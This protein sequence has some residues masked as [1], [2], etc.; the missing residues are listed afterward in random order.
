MI[1]IQMW[2]KMSDRITELER[3]IEALRELLHPVEAPKNE[4][5]HLPKKAQPE[6]RR[7]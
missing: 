7:I 6:P 2:Q 4:T 1:N 3:Q 5:L